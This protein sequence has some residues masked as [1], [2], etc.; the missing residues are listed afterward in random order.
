MFKHSI[1][2][3]EHFDSSLTVSFLK[4]SKMSSQQQKFINLFDSDFF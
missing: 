2:L 1:L 3:M 4:N